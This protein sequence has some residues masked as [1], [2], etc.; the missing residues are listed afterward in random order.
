VEDVR[1]R[2]HASGLAQR[3][4]AE[5]DGARVVLPHAEVRAVDHYFRQGL[6]RGVRGT[7]NSSSCAAGKLHASGRTRQRHGSYRS[8]SGVL[9]SREQPNQ[10]RHTKAEHRDQQDRDDAGEADVD[11]VQHQ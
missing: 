1:A 2:Q 5:T 10:T 11:V 8:R 4:L 9:Q 3:H 6:Y 7:L